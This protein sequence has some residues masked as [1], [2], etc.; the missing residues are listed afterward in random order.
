[1][2]HRAGPDSA[3]RRSNRPDRPV[4]AS[5]CPAPTNRLP[6]EIIGRVS[7]VKKRSA[8]EA[9]DSIRLGP[10]HGVIFRPTRPVSHEEGHATED[11]YVGWAKLSSRLCTPKPRRF[12][13]ASLCLWLV[14]ARHG[15]AVYCQRPCSASPKPSRNGIS[16]SLRRRVCGTWVKTNGPDKKVP[17]RSRAWPGPYRA[18]ATGPEYPVVKPQVGWAEGPPSGDSGCGCRSGSRGPSEGSEADSGVLFARVPC[19]R[20]A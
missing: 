7:L 4:G 3:W 9:R 16:L 10:V 19:T 20:G 14:P 5:R 15:S 8:V 12:S 18:P 17:G 13:R 11:A 1:M 2:R 6:T